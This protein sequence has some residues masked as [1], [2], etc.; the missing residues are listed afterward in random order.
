MKAIDEIISA[1]VGLKDEDALL[2]LRAQRLS[3]LGSFDEGNP[4]FARVRDQCLEELDAIE[5]GLLKLRS[6]ASLHLHAGPAKNDYL[7]AIEEIPKVEFSDSARAVGNDKMPALEDDFNASRFV[8]AQSLADGELG[9]FPAF[10]PTFFHCLPPDLYLNFRTNNAWRRDTGETVSATSLV[11]VS[12]NSDAWQVD[13]FGA[14]SRVSPD[15][16]ALSDRGAVILDRSSNIAWFSGAP[17]ASN[18]WTL[19]NATATLFAG[20]GPGPG[21]DAYLI[22]ESSSVSRLMPPENMGLKKDAIYTGSFIVKNLSS[23]ILQICLPAAAFGA[24]AYANFDILTGVVCAVGPAST[25]RIT[26]YPNGWFKCEVTATAAEAAINQSISILSIANS[27]SDKKFGA[28]NRQFLIW[29]CQMEQK[30]T[31]TAPIFT[32]GSVATRQADR[33]VFSELPTFG[34]SYSV[35]ATGTPRTPTANP[36]IQVIVE[37]FADGLNRPSQ[38][39]NAK[40]ANAFTAIVGGSD[41]NIVPEGAP[42]WPDGVSGTLA[43]AFAADDQAVAYNG[44]LGVANHRILPRQPVSVTIGSGND[45]NGFWWNGDVA[46]IAIWLT[47]RIPNAFLKRITA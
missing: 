29:N 21:L 17:E 31:S 40:T 41:G 28:A 43:T 47:Q 42:I 22:E 33:V 18:G 19:E 4:F 36:N 12:R 34:S 46:E 6:P 2:S 8:E 30:P 23:H 38:R 9:E 26:S 45:G 32:A 11:K 5:G 7:S 39:R 24:D 20:A 37:L 15:T 35:W 14:W 25:A 1:Y 10:L 13:S 44:L 3:L 27:S 16:L